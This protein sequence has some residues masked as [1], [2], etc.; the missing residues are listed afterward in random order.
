MTAGTLYQKLRS[1]SPRTGQTQVNPSRTRRTSKNASFRACGLG[2][3]FDGRAW[4]VTS[5]LTYI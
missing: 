2:D 1:R 5:G 3:V 4:L